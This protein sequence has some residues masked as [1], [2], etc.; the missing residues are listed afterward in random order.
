MQACARYLPNITPV[1]SLAAFH[2]KYSHPFG[3]RVVRTLRLES[4][5][6]PVEH[7]WWGPRW[8]YKPPLLNHFSVSKVH[9]WVH[10]SASGRT[11]WLSLLLPFFWYH[12]LDCPRGSNSPA[13]ST[14]WSWPS[15]WG[16]SHGH[17]NL[18]VTI[19]WL[20]KVNESQ[21]WDICWKYRKRSLSLRVR[22]PR[23]KPGVAGVHMAM[24]GKACLR[25]KAMGKIGA[26]RG[27]GD[28][29]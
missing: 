7:V 12:Q 24:W 2:A 14:E 26:C 4:H 1:T 29:F 15:S 21:L 23:L 6:Q 27:K 18:L 28:S 20:I 3:V 11:Q 16:W 17:S 22:V 19:R 13:L 8:I 5:S 9:H 25:M 10:S